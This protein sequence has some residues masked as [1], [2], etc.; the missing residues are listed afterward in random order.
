MNYHRKKSVLRYR[1][2]AVLLFAGLSISM[3][4]CTPVSELAEYISEDDS[5]YEDN[6]SGSD[7]D[8][9]ESEELIFLD[10][11]GEEHRMMID[12]E[13]PVNPYDPAGFV[14][15]GDKLS[16]N[17]EG[18]IYELG[19]DVSHHQ[20]EIDWQK[21]ANDGYDFA[22]LRIGYRGYGQRGSLNTDKMFEKNYK[23]AREAGLKLGVY[24]FAQ[25][26]NEEEAEEEAKYVLGLL[27]GRKLEL[28]IVYD[29]E[30][31]LDDEA[32]TDN[33]TPEQFTAN[34]KVFCKTVEDAGYDPMIYA[35]M[36]W[37]AYQ[38]DLSQ[39]SD[40]P[41]W[42]ADYEKLPQTPYDFKIWQYGCKGNVDGIS[43]DCDLNI[44]LIP[45]DEPVSE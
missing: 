2:L 35:N 33:V 32:R 16:Y 15:D 44:R 23:K 24:F 14:H 40:Y 36:V 21:V 4:G 25:A 27:D 9:D 7:L 6:A 39:L 29:P 26:I 42:Y 41:L 45:E 31:I 10:A 37:E 30:S 8:V 1:T 28:P 34:T 19:I 38:L 22:I 11:H 13:V 18:Y 43:G 17:G 3:T 12:P 20:G 5:K